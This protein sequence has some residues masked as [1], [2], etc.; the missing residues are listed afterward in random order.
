MENIGR[1]FEIN[2]SRDNMK[3]VQINTFPNKSTGTIM[4]EIHQKLQDEEI[5]SYV[6]WGRGRKSNNKHEIFMNDKIGVYCHA[7]YTRLTDKTGFASKRSTKQLIKKLEEIKPDIIHLHN[8]HGYYINIEL[9]FNYLKI[10]QIKTI[11]TLH[12]CWSFTGHCPY[13]EYV[14]CD[15]WKKVCYQCPQISEYP[16]SYVDQSKWNYEKKKE[17]FT[18]LNMT[19][20][21]PSKWLANLVKQ[22]FLSDYPVKVIYN[23]INTDVFKPIKSDFKKEYHIENKKMILGVASEWTA[24]KGYQDFLK[25]SKILDDSIRIVMV[26]LNDQQL[27]NL[28]QN[29]IGIQRTESKEELVKIYSAADVFFNATYDDN[30]PTTNLEAIACGTPVVTY[31]TGGSP[32]CIDNHNGKVIEQG[33]YDLL[34]EI[35]SNMNF[36]IDQY[37]IR[38]RFNKEIMINE[39]VKV[40]KESILEENDL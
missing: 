7:L 26:G 29:I 13:F 24:R 12:D 3:I 17:L 15:K 23:G 4:M 22:S 34:N 8:I 10:N 32:E 21:T 20:I 40:Y 28:P 38:N 1:Y 16:K 30:F 9:L 11:W 39:Y 14:N 19:I 5:E 31:N 2:K 25:L 18:G 37:E 35:V 33:K 27:Q 6:V 36:K